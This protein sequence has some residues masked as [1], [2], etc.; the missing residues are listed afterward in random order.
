M[1]KLRIKYN[2]YKLIAIM[3]T[4]LFSVGSFSVCPFCLPFYAGTFGF[5]GLRK[6]P[7]GYYFFAVLALA[8]LV[9]L[10]YALYLCVKARQYLWMVAVVCGFSVTIFSKLYDVKILLYLGLT[11]FVISIFQI[12]KSYKSCSVSENKKTKNKT[13]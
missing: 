12:K 9:S 11:I 13:N 8:M 5:L 1:T 6:G 4:A 2:I 10:I 3:P 7:C